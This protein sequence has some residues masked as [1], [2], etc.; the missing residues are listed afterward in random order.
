MIRP[1][2]KYK[3]GERV[4]VQ[5]WVNSDYGTIISIDWIYHRRS[6][7]HCWGYKVEF[8]G[9]GAGLTMTY[10]PEGYLRAL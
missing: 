8:E 3:V 10:I 2:R 6:S 4:N 7:D 9:D 5:G 1:D